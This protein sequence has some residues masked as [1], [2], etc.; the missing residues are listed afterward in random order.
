MT[1]Q[2]LIK[3]LEPFPDD[4]EVVDTTFYS[5]DGV[6]ESTWEHTNYPYDKPDK[7]VIMI[8]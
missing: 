7:Q 4:M 8:Y 6:Q 1:K 2:E 5:I 3:L